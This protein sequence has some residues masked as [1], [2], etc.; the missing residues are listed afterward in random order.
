MY[1]AMTSDRRRGEERRVERGRGET[2]PGQWVGACFQ[3]KCRRPSEAICDEVVYISVSFWLDFKPRSEPA[4]VF[5]LSAF[6][7]WWSL[8][9]WEREREREGEKNGW[10]ASEPDRRKASKSILSLLVGFLFSVLF[11]FFLSFDQ[12]LVSG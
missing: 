9:E 2:Q 3:K 6:F 7:F 8:D 10:I 5:F 11:S 1:N 12:D 4:V